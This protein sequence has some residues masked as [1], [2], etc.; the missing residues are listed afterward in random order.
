MSAEL[1]VTHAHAAQAAVL[2]ALLQAAFGEYHGKLD[3]PSGAPGVTRKSRCTV[4][5]DTRSLRSWKWK[6]G[7]AETC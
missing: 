5:P 7:C 3:P 6:S 2:L 1:D 4:T